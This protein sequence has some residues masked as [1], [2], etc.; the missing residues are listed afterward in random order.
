M[1]R[2][3]SGTYSW[4]PFM[5]FTIA[6]VLFLVTGHSATL[7]PST[8]I[9]LAPEA[10]TQVPDSISGHIQDSGGKPVMNVKVS[11]IYRT[12]KA[13][14]SSANSDAD[15]KFVIS[16]RTLTREISEFGLQFE[17]EGYLLV[18][19][20]GNDV[21]A[22]SSKVILYTLAEHNCLIAD[23]F[24]RIGNDIAA[25]NRYQEAI[26]LQPDLRAANDGLGRSLER[27]GKYEQA[28]ALYQDFISRFPDS[29]AVAE[30]KARIL[31]I[32]N[33]K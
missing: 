28:V 24:F 30:F 5:R 22:K 33:K 7:P 11:I 17:K 26:R 27:M 10:Q 25:S 1:Q 32:Q 6:A 12:T 16:A 14:L 8:T 20:N 13:V 23:F 3:K 18:Q 9:L 2:G 19:L 15:G 31:K 4:R 29:P 21:Y